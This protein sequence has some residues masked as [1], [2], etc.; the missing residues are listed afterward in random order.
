MILVLCSLSSDGSRVV[1]EQCGD[2]NGSDSGHVR[3]YDYQWV[4]MGSS[5]RRY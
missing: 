2:G 4:C 5:G 3:I 1:L